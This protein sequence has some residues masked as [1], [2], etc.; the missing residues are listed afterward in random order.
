[1]S[2]IPHLFVMNDYFFV[3]MLL[4]DNKKKQYRGH[5]S[6]FEKPSLNKLNVLINSLFPVLHSPVALFQLRQTIQ[7]KR[8]KLC[9]F[10]KS[11]LII[12]FEGLERF[13]TVFQSRNVLSY[14]LHLDS[15]SE[16]T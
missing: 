11:S 9:E 12:L 7:T 8:L 13:T 14:Y 5:C 16:R 10:I 3:D 4:L 1:M 15:E 2:R 6:C